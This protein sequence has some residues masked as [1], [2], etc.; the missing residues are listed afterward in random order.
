MMKYP[1][2]MCPYPPKPSYGP[3]RIL[4]CRRQ[5]G[6]PSRIVYRVAP[7]SPLVILHTLQRFQLAFDHVVQSVRR[8]D[9]SLAAVVS[10]PRSSQ[11]AIA[12]EETILAVKRCCYNRRQRPALPLSR[13]S[14][15]RPNA[16]TEGEALRPSCLKNR[17]ERHWCG[18]LY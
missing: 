17:L 1:Q 3:L 2:I 9:R 7:K 18:R 12:V 8:F 5:V 14:G 6:K 4:Q 13:N 10:M 11:A 15:G 16:T